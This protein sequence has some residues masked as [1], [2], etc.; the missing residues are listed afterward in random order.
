[1]KNLYKI[2]NLA[3]DEYMFNG[4]WLTR[5]EANEL[6]GEL[7]EEKKMIFDVACH[8]YIIIERRTGNI[9]NGCGLDGLEDLKE[10]GYNGDEFM[11]QSM[12]VI[13]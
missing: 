3:E 11:I 10:S 4:E 5:E 2:Y 12:Q 7:A 8:S 9:V 1:M 13:N 6:L